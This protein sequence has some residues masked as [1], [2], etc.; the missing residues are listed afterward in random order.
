[1][2]SSLKRVIELKDVAKNPRPPRRKKP[3][4]KYVQQPNESD[5]KFMHRINLDCQSV[6]KEQAFEDK[7]KVKIKRNQATGKVE[8]VVKAGKDQLWE[9]MKKLKKEQKNKS[10][11]KKATEEKPRL[12]KSQ[13]R[14]LKLKEKKQ[15]KA[16]NNFTFDTQKDEVRFGEVVHEPPTLVAPRKTEKNDNK[17]KVYVFIY[18]NL[19]LLHFYNFIYFPNCSQEKKIYL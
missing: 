18:F 5:K 2:S 16:E 8:E 14:S 7:Y 9:Y 4:L 13:K 6:I 17:R 10:K 3:A 1:M 12:T 11:K 19:L 15:K